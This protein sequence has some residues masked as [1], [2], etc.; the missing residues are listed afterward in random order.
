MGEKYGCLDYSPCYLQHADPIAKPPL[1]GTPFPF[2]LS[3]PPF[4]TRFFVI[5]GHFSLEPSPLEPDDVHLTF[6]V[7]CNMYETFY[8]YNIIERVELTYTI[9]TKQQIT[10]ELI[11]KGP[12]N[13]AN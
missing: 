12:F 8:I 7:R 13:F 11:L 2:F 5:P 4:P 1:H 10:I 3:D 6:V 9:N